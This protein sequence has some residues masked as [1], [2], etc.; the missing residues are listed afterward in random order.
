MPLK[1]DFIKK[2]ERSHM[3]KHT[4]AE[5]TYVK[6]GEDGLELADPA[7]EKC[8]VFLLGGKGMEIEMSVAEKLGL[9]NAKP[10]P[11]APAEPA[12]GKKGKE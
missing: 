6:E 1:F 9:V 11:E 5:R 12:K 4:L 7:K 3:P 8:P 2:N 10:K